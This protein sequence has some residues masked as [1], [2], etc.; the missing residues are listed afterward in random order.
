MT[1]SKTWESTGAAW[2]GSSKEDV[3]DSSKRG[4][5][6]SGAGVL[7]ADGVEEG[8]EIGGVGEEEAAEGLEGEE[9][10]VLDGVGVAGVVAEMAAHDGGHGDNLREDHEIVER[11]GDRRQQQRQHS[12]G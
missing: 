12:L 1:A 2:R 11:T 4:S 3:V 7:I 8:A 5:S 6:Y 10:R 9:R